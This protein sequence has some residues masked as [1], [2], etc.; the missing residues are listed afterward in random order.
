MNAGDIL[1]TRTA[2]VVS[3]RALL[4]GHSNEACFLYSTVVLP[5]CRVRRL[6]SSMFECFLCPSHFFFVVCARSF[7]WNKKRQIY[8][9]S[10][11]PSRPP[12]AHTF[13]LVCVCICP[14]FCFCTGS[15][16]LLADTLAHLV[17]AIRENITISRAHVRHAGSISSTPL[18]AV[19]LVVHTLA[20][21]AVSATS[22]KNEPK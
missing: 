22:K 5:A 19:Q 18:P 2:V 17:G 6:Y 4:F 1:A 16:E 11:T 14:C 3:K 15:G 7:W 21:A 12:F 10:L 9:N 13:V 20:A 8:P